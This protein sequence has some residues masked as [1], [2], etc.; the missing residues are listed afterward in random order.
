[1]RQLM[2]SQLKNVSETDQERLLSMV[3]ENPDLFGKM[4]E[5]IQRKMKEGESQMTATMEVAREHEGALRK[6]MGQ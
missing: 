4:A 3:E 2:K 5:E 6:A 1:M